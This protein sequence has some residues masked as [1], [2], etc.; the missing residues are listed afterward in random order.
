MQ[1]LNNTQTFLALVRAG[2]WE[3]DVQILPYQDINWQVVYRLA[4]EQSV[5][6]LVL[7]GL[8]H[9]DVKPPKEVLLQWIGEVQQ[10][11][12]RNKVLNSFLAEIIERL[13]KEDVYCLLVKG[14]GV[15]QCYEKPLW[16]ISGDIDLFL[17]NLHYHKARLFFEYATDMSFSVTKR[18]NERKHLDFTF[19]SWIIELH[20]TLHTNLSRKIDGVVDLVQEKVFA[21]DDVR[22]WQNGDTDIYIPAPNNEVIFVFTHILQHFFRGGVGLKQLCDLSRLLWTYRDSIDRTLLKRRLDD[23]GLLKEWIAFGCVLVDDLGMP[24]ESIP[25]YDN[26]HRRKR[27]RLLSFILEYGNMGHNKD[28]CYFTKYPTIIRKIVTFCRMT[29]D[30]LKLSLIFPGDSVRFLIRFFIDGIKGVNE[31]A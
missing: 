31:G 2:L 15:A 11:E 21:E 29:K 18:N 3:K 14:Q 23:M 6:G 26:T 1:S 20:G 25:F 13:R 16:R 7:A 24:K 10:I 22:V 30:S 4:N 5:L 19:D 12:Q 9:S 8:E 28:Y 27:D 17:D